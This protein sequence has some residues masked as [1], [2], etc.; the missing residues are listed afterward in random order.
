MTY[1]KHFSRKQT[2]QNEPIPGSTQT[3]NNAGGYAWAVNDWVRL[4]R[5]LI[6][7]AEGGAYYTSERKLTI[8]NAEAVRRCIETDGKRAVDII[9]DVS[10]K[11]RAPKNSP[12]IFAL[13]MVFAFGNL[14]ARRYAGWKMVC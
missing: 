7:G 4:E 3:A 2:P 10:D 9:F 5:F 12:A 14:D 6:L 11:G 1:A 13:A 8:E